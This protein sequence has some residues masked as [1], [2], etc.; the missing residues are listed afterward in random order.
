[1]DSGRLG[2]QTCTDT[3]TTSV[4][5]LIPG[6]PDV[7]LRVRQKRRYPGMRGDLALDGRLVLSEN[8]TLILILDTGMQANV[9]GPEFAH[10]LARPAPAASDRPSTGWARDAKLVVIE[11]GTLIIALAP[12]ANP[13]AGLGALPKRATQMVRAA[14][15]VPR[16]HGVVPHPTSTD[17][18]ATGRGPRAMGASARAR[19]PHSASPR[20]V[21]AETTLAGIDVVDAAARLAYFDRPTFSVFQGITSGLRSPRDHAVPLE[22]LDDTG[23]FSSFT[24][25]AT[26]S[27]NFTPQGS[28]SR[29]R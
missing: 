20:S 25:E 6:K 2:F 1:M 8:G 22:E 5:L 11:M 28:H 7:V 15:R 16:W 9:T 4:T 12:F 17:R 24:D 18:R 14:V 29:A 10:T 26:R 3:S 19:Q 27:E 23:I 21:A 13:R